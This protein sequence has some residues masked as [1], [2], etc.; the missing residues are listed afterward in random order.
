MKFLS[1]LSA[2]A[3]LLIPACGG[4]TSPAL[5][6]GDGS[7]SGTASQ[8]TTLRI[9]V[10]DAPFPSSF[11]E[12]ASVVINEVRV[13]D[14]DSD[15][16]STVFAGSSTIDLVPLTGGVS[17]LLIEA[18]IK[19]GSYDEVRLIVDAGRV[20]LADTAFT[21][22]GDPE[23][24]V[25]NGTLKFPS[26]AQTGIK[27]KIDSPIVVTTGLSADLMLDFDLTK[28]FV[29]NGPPSHAPGVRRVLF[30]PVVRANNTTTGGSLRLEAISDSATPADTSDDL[31]LA[32]ATV[33]VCDAADL[34]V[35]TVLADDLGIAVVS[36]A[37]GTYTV[38]VEAAAHET[39][40]VTDVT[41]ALANLT[42]VGLV[43]LVV[44]EAEINGSVR[45][46]GATAADTTDDL[47]LVG[48]NVEVRAAGDSVLVDSA[49]TDDQG[50]FAF[51]MLA[52]GTYDLRVIAAGHLTL[53]VPGVDAAAPG[54]F[55]PLDLVLVAHTRD[56]KGNVV[57]NAAAALVGA[58]V[59]I[60]NAEGT[61]LGS[62]TTDANG[63]YT[64]LGIPTGAHTITVTPSGSTTGHVEAL[65]VVGTDPVSDQTAD[66]ALP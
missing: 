30:K 40:S 32:G 25:T 54:L 27:V 23:F 26:G 43:T 2:F 12:E 53:D 37:P 44:S 14:K 62:T 60:Q 9:S 15:T 59:E 18:D 56:V 61:S 19:P 11:V 47:V 48:A 8:A 51:P 33:R 58:T 17:E 16:W 22:T 13:R 66:I 38:K 50:S 20:L 6:G 10:T 28:S 65:V 63:D 41:V 46:D 24:T 57:D 39:A 49:T 35:A 7:G 45:S 3:L 4:G 55:T 36:I 52:P 29:F 21:A 5:S 31:A 64:L 42:D 1:L 34:E